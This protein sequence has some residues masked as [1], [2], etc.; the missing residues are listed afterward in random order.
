[1]ANTKY[2]GVITSEHNQQPNFMAWLTNNLN[3]VE[4]IYQAMTDTITSF[5]IDTAV[6]DQLD[7]MGQILG[8]IRTL[9]FQPTHGESSILDDETYRTYLKGKITQNQWDGTIGG[10]KTILN[11]IFPS[12]TISVVDNQ[13]MSMTVTIYGNITNLEIDLLQNHYL[14]PKPETVRVIFNLPIGTFE[15]IT[16][17]IVGGVYTPIIDATK[18]F[19]D[20]AQTTG[21]TLSGMLE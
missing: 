11:T 9:T 5:D 1:M 13:D 7:I 18:G 12:Y 16:V 10:F 14:I 3:K 6:G 8:R 21:G 19:A 2:L 4:D 15:L 20:L 17:N